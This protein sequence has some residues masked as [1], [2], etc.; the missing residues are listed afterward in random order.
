MK[1]RLADVDMLHDEKQDNTPILTVS[2]KHMTEKKSNTK[3]GQ[4]PPISNKSPERILSGVQSTPS[5]PEYLSGKNSKNNKLNL[6]RLEE[7]PQFV[8]KTL[9]TEETPRF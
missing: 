4:L 3:L 6:S 5:F 8:D 2:S 1:K 9:A 7:N